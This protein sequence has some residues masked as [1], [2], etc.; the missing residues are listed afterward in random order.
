MRTTRSL[1]TLSLLA[2]GCD[3]SPPEAPSTSD[4]DVL[5]EAGG[6]LADPQTYL[7]DA[8]SGDTICFGPGVWAVNLDFGGKDLVVVGLDGAEATTLDGGQA[9]PV[10]TFSG[11]ETAAAELRGFTLLGGAAQTDADGLTQGGGV[12]ILDASPTLS[13]L[14]IRENTC[15]GQV[16]AGAGVA[17][18]GGA[19]T[20][21]DVS[22]VDNHAVGEGEMGAALGAGLAARESELTL[23]RVRISGNVAEASFG[24]YG[25]GLSVRAGVVTVLESVIDE[26]EGAASS[27]V[28]GGGVFATEGQLILQ[29]SSVS[30]NSASAPTVYGG[31]LAVNTATVELSGV[32]VDGNLTA[33]DTQLVG[34]GLFI[35]T[36]AAT[37][38]DVS[39]DAN[40]ADC[41]GS[42][43][44]VGF[45][46]VGAE[47][48]GEEVSALQAI[49]NIGH[50][51]QNVY[52]VGHL[53]QLA[54]HVA[55]L[56][57]R[58][59]LASSGVNT[60]TAGLYITDS[61]GRFERLS[62]TDN[63]AEAPSVDSGGLRVAGG[64]EPT[65]DNVVVA[66]NSA[67]GTESVLAGGATFDRSTR[68]VLTNASIVGNLAQAPEVFAGGFTVFNDVQMTVRNTDISFNQVVADAWTAGGAGQVGVVPDWQHN[69]VYGNDHVQYGGEAGDPTGFA[70]N[71][72]EDPGYVDLSADLAA[73]WDLRLDS[74]SALIDAGA[75]E[76]TDADGSPSDIGA[77]GGPL[78]AE[79]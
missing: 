33:A 72:S 55:D 11:G 26:N 43:W 40:E 57:V 14:T 46:L 52:S 34:G 44:G 7:D 18:T 51:E 54:G 48:G 35:A 59:G 31:G 12:L 62:L 66:H 9:G 38:T 21:R 32:R 20:L 64:T 36:S 17:V 10:V 6:D 65:L 70:G 1:I 53:Q 2:L 78:G 41:A 61:A 42:I 15:A 73:G 25:A 13:E 49:G 71:L 74:G 45:A 29:G 28:S 8:Q 63:L 60:W 69:N 68:A 77:F 16:C 3:R 76:L 50:A 56:Q 47:G 37:L 23:E 19:P 79:W 22:I 27:G 75:P 4:C 67:V 30:G 24:V 58:E 39:A 5:L